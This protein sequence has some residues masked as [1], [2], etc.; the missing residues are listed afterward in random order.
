MADGS[1]QSIAETLLQN[2]LNILLTRGVNGLYL[3]AVDDALKMS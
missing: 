3:Y 2:E 1:K